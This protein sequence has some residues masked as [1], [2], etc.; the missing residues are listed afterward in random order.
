MVAIV[1]SQPQQR[2]SWGPEQAGRFISKH[3]NRRQHSP[4]F[5]FLRLPL[6]DPSSHATTLMAWPCRAYR[7]TD[8]EFPH[9]RQDMPHSAYYT[10]QAQLVSR[11]QHA[12]QAGKWA[13]SCQ[14]TLVPPFPCQAP[15]YQLGCQAARRLPSRL[16]NKDGRIQVIGR[17][18]LRPGTFLRWCDADALFSKVSVSVQ[19]RTVVG[20]CICFE[21]PMHSPVHPFTKNGP[22]LYYAPLCR[23]KKFG[24]DTLNASHS[25]RQI[26]L[27][28][29]KLT[30]CFSSNSVVL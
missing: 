30:Q 9:G 22:R 27:A 24:N 29:S 19:C 6:Q 14:G 10:F 25:S 11:C 26:S 1:I 21:P 8:P 28:V 20:G 18:L 2:D 7:I 12:A 13:S 23:K 15:N 5:L 17:S 4:I 3:A 16:M